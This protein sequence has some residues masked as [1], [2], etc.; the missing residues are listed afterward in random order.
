MP[1]FPDRITIVRKR[2][3]SD[4]AG[5]IQVDVPPGSGTAIANFM[6]VF[7]NLPGGATPHRAPLPNLAILAE[8]T[9]VAGVYTASFWGN[10]WAIQP[11]NPNGSSGPRGAH[12]NRRSC[13]KVT[14][15]GNA[16]TGTAT[17]AFYQDQERG[18]WETYDLRDAVIE[19]NSL[20]DAV[21]ITFPANDSNGY[22]GHFT[23]EIHPL[24]QGKG[25]TK[26]GPLV[27]VPHVTVPQMT[28]A[29]HRA[30]LCT[31]QAIIQ[32]PAPPAQ[33]L[34]AASGEGR[35]GGAQGTPTVASAQ[36][37]SAHDQFEPVANGDTMEAD[38]P[39]IQE[40]EVAVAGELA[41]LRCRGMRE[42]A[43]PYENRGGRR[44]EHKNK[45]MLRAR[46]RT[47]TRR[48]RTC[49]KSPS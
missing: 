1:S 14:V 28:T 21:A 33:D 35:G 38:A 42:G 13:F 11:P 34:D 12:A 9:T 39:D 7:H 46:T 24:T 44:V 26:G 49:R 15:T 45:L 19:P 30:R 6:H 47:R 36:A 8:D 25:K 4:T 16:H 40:Q 23:K 18:S 31:S 17:L 5:V 43:L 10:D 2:F 48:R 32:A 27:T 37:E 41:K 20:I 22:T 29:I 3:R